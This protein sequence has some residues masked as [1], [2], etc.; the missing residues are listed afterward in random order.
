MAI[1]DWLTFS[2]LSG[3]GDTI[4]TVTASSSVLER[5]ANFIVSGNTK[6]VTGT[7]IQN[8]YEIADNT[9]LYRTSSH[10]ILTP[11][12]ERFGERIVSNTY[13]TS[14]DLGT[15]VFDFPLTELTFDNYNVP[16]LAIAWN[17]QYFGSFANKTDL[18]D[19]YLPNSVVGINHSSFKT[20]TNLT[21]ITLGDGVM[22]AGDNAFEQCWLS[23]LTLTQK[24][25]FYL[26]D[27]AF[28]DA[29]MLSSITLAGGGGISGKNTSSGSTTIPNSFSGIS[30]LGTIYVPADVSSTTIHGKPLT[31]SWTTD[32]TTVE[33]SNR[34]NFWLSQCSLVFDNSGKTYTNG[35]SS[36]SATASIVVHSDTNWELSKE[37][38]SSWITV[39]PTS[40][41]SGTTT[42]TIDATPRTATA[43][44]FPSIPVRTDRLV[45]T[46]GSKVKYCRVTQY[47]PSVVYYNAPSVS[48][49]IGIT[50]G[51]NINK[52]F[53]THFNT[54][55]HRGY[56]ELHGTYT[57]INAGVFSNTG[58]TG[59]ELC[60][61][62]KLIKTDAFS[63]STSLNRIT[64]HTCDYVTLEPG[65][66]NGLPAVGNL[67]YPPGA[68]PNFAHWLEALGPGWNGYETA[69]VGSDSGTLTVTPST[70]SFPYT[71]GSQVFTITS[72][73]NWVIN[74]PHTSSGIS[75]SVSA[76]SGITGQYTVT[77]T[78]N[79]NEDM[80]AKS[81]TFI[82]SNGG[83][84][85]NCT[86]NQAASTVN[87]IRVSP[88]SLSFDAS[89]NT[90]TS[91]TITVTSNNPYRFSVVDDSGVGIQLKPSGGSWQPASNVSGP[92]GTTTY[93]VRSSANS[94]Y[95]F[96]LHS[97]LV[98]TD[99]TDSS[100]TAHVDIT[101]ATRNTVPVKI[102]YKS[103]N[104]QIIV[105][106]SG[107]FYAKSGNNLAHVVSNTY[108]NGWGEWELDVCTV[109]V[110]TSAFTSSSTISEI[111]LEAP[112]ER[113]NG[114]A[115]TECP[116]LTAVTLNNVD[117]IGAAFGKSGVKQATVSNTSIAGRLTKNAFE[118]CSALTSVT[119]TGNIEIGSYAFMD[120]D[121]RSLYIPSG[122]TFTEDS[123]NVFARNR[124]LS[125]VTLQPGGSNKII[126]VY[127]FMGTPLTDVTIPQ[128][129][130]GVSAY[131]FG[132]C[133]Q[134]TAI[135]LSST[136]R[137]VGSYGGYDFRPLCSSSPLKIINCYATTAPNIGTTSS[138]NPGVW[139]FYGTDANNGVLHYPSGSNYSTWM[140]N[141]T[142]CLGTYNW[143]SVGDL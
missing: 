2:Q 18:T 3:S 104:G 50:P 79:E 51:V 83:N 98:M 32:R 72:Q 22:V 140:A 99:T 88:T 31:S 30:A 57:Q 126:P 87:R 19:I 17:N 44:W 123:T 108:Q 12:T 118:T 91:Q 41:A 42:V 138:R 33:E 28:L 116:N 16:S 82:I 20:C 60:Q 128:G 122:V 21:G 38:G 11:S 101:K 29:A 75:Y 78:V 58:Y 85:V 80:S 133:S 113:V 14:K 89:S 69:S 92:S 135:T 1:P 40:G 95:V 61:G 139:Y 68:G 48:S 100:I 119:L 36:S 93:N 53:S 34:G 56:Y 54:S 23:G 77:L 106:A 96:P 65:A 94:Y 109:D 7:A 111:V 59:I 143:T 35:G 25:T 5:L 137:S 115:F 102:K 10:T 107:A 26:G 66:F 37:A 141:E 136:V 86:I 46:N 127:A 27:N 142:G 132:S 130:T 9:I 8:A 81:Q 74:T 6:A 55:T 52:T 15:M 103:T 73:A 4:I 120:C 110:W 70:F 124:N 131:A 64:A 71:G 76:T 47:I 114:Y 63:G 125:S 24:S 39:S 13:D 112:V 90:V 43:S 129:Y 67:Y 105:P 49:S 121:I 134:L 45:F 97:Q 117:F 62:L 84:L